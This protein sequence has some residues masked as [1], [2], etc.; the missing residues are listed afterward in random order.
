MAPLLPNR[1]PT[2]PQRIILL[3]EGMFEVGPED[4]VPVLDLL[5][6]GVEFSLQFLGDADAEDFADVVR[7][8]AKTL[9]VCLHHL[10]QAAHDTAVRY[11]CEELT[12][13]ETVFPGTDLRLVYKLGS[14]QIP[15]DREFGVSTRRL[16]ALGSGRW[17]ECQRGTQ[18]C[19]RHRCRSSR[20]A[21]GLS[22]YRSVPRRHRSSNSAFI[23][24]PMPSCW[25]TTAVQVGRVITG[26]S[27]ASMPFS[28]SNT[29]SFMGS[30]SAIRT[31]TPLAT[32]STSRCRWTV[33]ID[34]DS[35]SNRHT[36]PL[37][38]ACFTSFSS[39]GST[40]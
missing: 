27:S 21:G 6:R 30:D 20:Q 35:K 5:Q 11:L 39:S 7:G 13:T 10:T 15:R 31:C 25:N 14:A 19:A 23:A 16:R 28:P 2:Q 4:M 26:S 34:A 36:T 9:T 32:Y 22:H 12:A 17:Q 33:S 38:P 29:A 8:Q 24:S 37:R 18:E 3:H 40:A 1:F